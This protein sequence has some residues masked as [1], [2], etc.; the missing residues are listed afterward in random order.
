MRPLTEKTRKNL[1]DK[2]FICGRGMVEQ[3]HCLFYQG[4]QVDEPFAILPLCIFCH[5][6]NN[7]TIWQE[8]RERCELYALQK[9]ISIL[10]KFYSKGNWRQR[11][12]YLEGKYKL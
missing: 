9:G 11:L 7:G 3:H 6:G 4:R 10:E 2:C 1:K 8:V 12:N 5:R